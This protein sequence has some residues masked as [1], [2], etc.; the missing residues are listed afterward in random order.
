MTAEANLSLLRQHAAV[1]LAQQ[2]A[3]WIVK[4]RI[5]AQGWVKLSTLSAATLTRIANDY[6]REHPELLAEAAA[7][8]IVQNSTL[9]HRKRAARSRIHT[10][11]TKNHSP[12]LIAYLSKELNTPI[13]QPNYVDI[14]ETTELLEELPDDFKEGDAIEILATRYERDPAARRKCISYYGVRCTI[15]DVSLSEQYGPKVDGLIHVHHLTPLASIGKQSPVDPIRD[16]RPVCP[17]CHAVIH[18]TQPPR[19]LK[20]V[21][22][23]LR[24]L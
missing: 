6:L 22:E 13:P 17:N 8:P 4:R 12:G 24:K 21:K 19:T 3:L 20:Q 11:I 2:A 16:L 18:S 9:P 10:S 15:C 14:S 1:I 5:Q 23:M 7:D